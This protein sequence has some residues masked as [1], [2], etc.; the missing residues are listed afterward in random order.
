[1]R[2]T[3]KIDPRRI[4]ALAMDLDGTVLTPDARLGDRTLRV[5]KDC[6]NRGIGLIFCTGRSLEGAEPYRAVLGA[7]GPMVYFNG[8]KVMDMP[9]RTV[10][11]QTLLDKAAANFCVDLSRKLGVYCQIYFPGTRER[12]ADLLMAEYRSEE[13]ALYRNHT[14]VDTVIGD[15]KEALADPGCTGCI[16]SMFI[17]GPAQQDIIRPILSEQFGGRIYMTRT[18]GTFLEVMSPGVSKGR[19][20]KL[21]MDHLGLSPEELIA[22]G[23]GENDLPLFEAA[24][25]SA[26]PANAKAQ[27]LAAADFRI[28]SDAEEGAAAFLEALFS[29]TLPLG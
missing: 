9:G 27:V 2:N 3:K 14:G 25:F 22:L 6:L 12:P 29:G 1:M 17:A 19:G 13:T 5:L 11:S 4:K 8:A 28:G 10:L 15:L 23:D 18:Y 24:G 21:A 20:L 7:R 16:K 26:A